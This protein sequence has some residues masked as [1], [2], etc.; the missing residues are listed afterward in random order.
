[1]KQVHRSNIQNRTGLFWLTLT[2]ATISVHAYA[3]SPAA[4]ERSAAPSSILTTVST[5]NYCTGSGIAINFAAKG[6]YNADNV[7]IAQLSNARG[8]F[9]FPVEIGRLVGNTEGQIYASLPTNVV[10]GGSYRV[11]VVSTSPQSVSLKTTGEIT[12]TEAPAADILVSKPLHFSAD[13]P[14]VLTA[15]AGELYTWSNGEQSRSIAVHEPG[16]YI[17]QVA[18]A[19]GC[20]STSS[21]VVKSDVEARK[22]GTAEP[23]ECAFIRSYPNPACG[24]F[25]LLLNN[26]NRGM[27]QVQIISASGKVVYS[28]WAIV[29]AKKETLAVDLQATPAGTYL[30]KVTSGSEIQTTKVILKG[31]NG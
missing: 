23:L 8:S 28:H 25:Q 10:S 27:V 2:I 21:V 14:V 7:F 26:I 20:S 30:V 11:R 17:L 15:S 19:A 5:D 6:N 1:M 29:A 3:Q 22:E 16:T 13:N 4:S 31:I 18:N 12:I 9:D 24:A